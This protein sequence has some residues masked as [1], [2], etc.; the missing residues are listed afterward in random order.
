M[1][2]VIFHFPCRTCVFQDFVIRQIDTI[3]LEACVEIFNNAFEQNK[4][5]QKWRS[6]SSTRANAKS[7][8]LQP[9]KNTNDSHVSRDRE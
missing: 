9:L 2:L 7:C 6:H 3:K 1:I 5:S 8:E 4:F